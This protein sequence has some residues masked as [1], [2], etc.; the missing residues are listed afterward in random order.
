[1]A[2]KKAPKHALLGIDSTS[3]WGDNTT[4]LG[5]YAKEEDIRRE[6]EEIHAAMLRGDTT[7]Q[8]KYT[9][10]VAYRWCRL[11]IMDDEKI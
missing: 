8:L 5:W 1:M 3:C 11:R 7:Y 2:G 10:K 6:I 9:V 4:V